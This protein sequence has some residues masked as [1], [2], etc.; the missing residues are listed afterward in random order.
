[1]YLVGAEVIVPNAFTTF[2]CVKLDTR[3]THRMENCI[4]LTLGHQYVYNVRVMC[5]MCF[6]L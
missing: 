3:N 6:C 2:I 4:S 1:M 5:G